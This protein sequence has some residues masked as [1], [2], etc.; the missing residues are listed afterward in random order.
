[1]LTQTACSPN[2][3][4]PTQSSTN[5]SASPLTSTVLDEQVFEIPQKT[6]VTLA[7]SI[8]GN[9]TRE[10]LTKLLNDV[11]SQTRQRSGFKY[12][13]HPTNVL[14]FAYRTREHFKSDAGLWIAKLADDSGAIGQTGPVTIDF[15]DKQLAQVGAQPEEKAGLSEDK[16]KQIYKEIVAGEDKAARVAEQKYGLSE[17]QMRRTSQDKILGAIKKQNEHEESLSNK[18]KNDLAAKYKLSREQLDEIANEGLEKRWAMAK[19]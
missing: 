14:I 4:P 19:P 1:M 10:G 5:S 18:S 7:I 2:T 6:S 12:H 16:R 13:M 17:A 9:I 11:Y 15:D 3:S 8:S